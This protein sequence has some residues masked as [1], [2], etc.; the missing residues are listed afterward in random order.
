MHFWQLDAPEMPNATNIQKSVGLITF[1]LPSSTINDVLAFY[2]DK[3]TAD[4]WTADGKPTVELDKLGSDSFTKGDLK[5]SVIVSVADGA[6]YSLSL[7]SATP[8]K[9]K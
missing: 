4:G 6:T 2:T 5:I 1:D 7:T 9:V 8:N 3:L